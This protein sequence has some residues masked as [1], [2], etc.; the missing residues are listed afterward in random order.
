[1]S[2]RFVLQ[3]KCSK[4][5]ID[6]NKGDEYGQ[7]LMMAVGDDIDLTCPKCGTVW[8]FWIDVEPKQKKVG[9]KKINRKNKKK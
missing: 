4:C 9:K 1:M 2:D 7:R 3:L 8:R 6:L 5:N